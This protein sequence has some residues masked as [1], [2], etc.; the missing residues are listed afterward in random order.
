MAQIKI[1]WQAFGNKPERN[2]EITSVEFNCEIA[3]VLDQDI[4]NEIYKNT[5]L[6]SGFF[7]NK[8]EHLLAPNRTH[9]ALSVGDKIEIDNRA[10]IVADFGFELV[11][12]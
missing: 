3:D 1:T 5:N 2:R 9:T 7:W 11:G 8:M 12:A 6:Y 4:M 10:Y